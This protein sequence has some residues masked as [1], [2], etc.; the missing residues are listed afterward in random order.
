MKRE[1]RGVTPRRREPGLI[2]LPK[3]E[4]LRPNR[5]D[6]M[7]ERGKLEYVNPSMQIGNFGAPEGKAPASPTFVQSFPR[8]TPKER[9]A[10]RPLNQVPGYDR[11]GPR[12]PE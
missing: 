10:E 6:R 1:D 12:Q 5:R 2:D 9:K 3:R 11:F 7:P 8:R 4:E